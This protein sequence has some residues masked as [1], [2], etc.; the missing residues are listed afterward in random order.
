M[1]DVAAVEADLHGDALDAVEVLQEVAHAPAP[2]DAG[3]GM[4]DAGL[5]LLDLVGMGVEAEWESFEAGFDFAAVGDGFDKGADVGEEGG[6]SGFEEAGQM[7]HAAV[8]GEGAG[9]FG[10]DFDELGLRGIGAVLE[11]E[12][13]AGVLVGGVGTGFAGHEHVER[14][15]AAGEEQADEGAVFALGRGGGVGDAFG[16][17]EVEQGV[18]DGQ[19]GHALAAELTEETPTGE[20]GR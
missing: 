5:P 19:G 6:V 16:E 9:V 2:A 8:D 20:G 7:R 1:P 13:G 3:T 4:G 12:V 10:L 18:E 11:G 17:A 14:V 15:V